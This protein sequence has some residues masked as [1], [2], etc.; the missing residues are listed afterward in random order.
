MVNF[1]DFEKFV[2]QLGQGSRAGIEP[3]LCLMSAGWLSRSIFLAS[4]TRTTGQPMS[5]TCVWSHSIL[6][7]TTCF[8]RKHRNS[9][10]FLAWV[11]VG[12]N[13]FV[14]RNETFVFFGN[15][16][17]QINE[18]HG[19]HKMI[20]TWWLHFLRIT[21]DPPKKMGFWRCNYSRV[22][23]VTNEIPTSDGFA[24]PNTKREV[25]GP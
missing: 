23:W 14:E 21:W 20:F 8:Q 10:F 5:P 16:A 25:V 22:L 15:P 9:P 18:S 12:P 17:F 1:A 19:S 11:Y 24:L 13:L 2:K 3:K 6:Q 4:K 7:R